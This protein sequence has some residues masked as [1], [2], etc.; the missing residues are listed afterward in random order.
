VRR[1]LRRVLAGVLRSRRLRVDE[2]VERFDQVSLGSDPVSL[3]VDQGVDVD[4]SVRSF[5]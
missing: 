3:G 4:G 2:V 5:V 1:C